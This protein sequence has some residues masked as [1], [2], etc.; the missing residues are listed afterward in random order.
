[1]KG[2]RI[3]LMCVAWVL[4][5]VAVGTCKVDAKAAE[6]S[7]DTK[8]NLDNLV[9]CDWLTDGAKQTILEL[10]EE[11]GTVSV[12]LPNE[13]GRSTGKNDTAYL[14]VSRVN[15]I[16]EID[17]V[18]YEDR[19]EIL[20]ALASTE[21]GSFSASGQKYGVAAANTVSITW[22][23]SDSI[24][25]SDLKIKFN[26]MSA[27]YTYLPTQSTTVTKMDYSVSL[28]P[29]YGTYAYY[30]TGSASNPSSGVSYTK[31]L[32]SAWYSYGGYNGVAMLTIYY[33]N[34][35]SSTYMGSLGNKG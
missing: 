23:Y 16:E 13:Q 10:C 6:V 28:Q 19:E 32:N 22:S 30:Q 25:L 12:Y 17:G 15:S 20:I 1:M 9:E 35:D 4:V 27:K 31:S 34:G 33:A 26:S 29:P 24:T 21:N 2:K 14:M 7:Q 8:L 11:S 3:L 5:T 18:T